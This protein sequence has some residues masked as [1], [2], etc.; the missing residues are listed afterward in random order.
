VER[1]LLSGDPQILSLFAR[2]PFPGQPPEQ[3]R[4]VLWQYWFTGPREKRDQGLWWRRE[5]IGLYAPTLERFPN[6]KIGVLEFPEASPEF[7]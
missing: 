4:V 5:Q 7:K 3:I 2:D 1:H 6:G